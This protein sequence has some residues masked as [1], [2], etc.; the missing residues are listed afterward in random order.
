MKNVISKID[1]TD[2]VS[3]ITID[4]LKNDIN[5]IT[6]ILNALAEAGISLDMISQSPLI[7][8]HEVS[9]LFT[10]SDDD[11]QKALSVINSFKKEIPK[12]SSEINSG[13]TKLCVY[14]EQMNSTPGVAAAL[15]DV[16]AKNDIDLKLITTS[17]VDIS[18]LVS[19][20]DT[21]KAVGALKEQFGL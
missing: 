13:N 11:M 2:N 9:L 20:R 6:L 5:T 7:K 12:I 19:E 10:I 3:L 17:A 1:I 4:K 15:Y 16:L 21:D 14:G 8:S 18:F